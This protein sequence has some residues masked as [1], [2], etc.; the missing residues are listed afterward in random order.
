MIKVNDRFSFERDK[1]QWLLHESRLGKDREGNDKVHVDT[2]YHGSLKQVCEQVIDRSQGSDDCGL[3]DELVIY[4]E[5]AINSMMDH[6]EY[7]LKDTPE[8]D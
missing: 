3:L 6:A 2:S 7:I 5:D 1:Y 4:T 8:G